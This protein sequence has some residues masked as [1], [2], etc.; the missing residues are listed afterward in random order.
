MFC[1]N[2]SFSS[3][4]SVK[5]IKMKKVPT[6]FWV[7]AVIAVIWNAMGVMAFFAQINMSADA[8]AALPEAEQELYDKYPMWTKIA[9]AVA[10][11]GGLLGSIGL[12]MRKSWAS[13]ILKISLVGIIVQM[14]H[15]LFIAKAT[16]VYGPGAAVMPIMVVLF[17]VFLVWYARKCQVDGYLS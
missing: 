8:I 17:A 15:S 14:I 10:V 9:F 16:D 4:L 2:S 12:L 7:I 3:I 5:K 6:I 13:L 11:F 1:Q